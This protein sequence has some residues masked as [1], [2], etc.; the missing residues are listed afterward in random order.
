MTPRRVFM[1]LIAGVLV[2]AG[3]LW[4]VS[5]R[6]LEQAT[7][8]GDLVLPG[9]QKALNEVTEIRVSRGDGSRTTLKKGPTDWLVGE[10]DYPAD[11]GKVRKLLLDLGALSV[12]EEKTRNPEYYPQLGVEDSNSPKAG[13]TLLEIA[14]P[15]KSYALIVGKPARGQSGYVRVAHTAP[16]LLVQPVINVDGDP[17]H[18]IDR[19]VVDVSDQQMKEAVIEPAAGPAYTVARTAPQQN[20]YKVTPLPKGREL[21]SN[22][23]ANSVGSA[24]GS[25]QADDV[26]RAPAAAADAAKPDHG[27]FRTFNGLELEITGRT[28]GEHHYITL[29]ARAN[30]KEAQAEAGRINTRFPGWQIEI[31]AFNYQAIFKP[32]EE[33]LKKPEPPK[34]K[35]AKPAPLKK[36]ASP[37]QKSD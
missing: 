30:S 36:S 3:S 33:L 37:Q 27:I 32:R 19:A 13:G 20:D 7:M 11:S 6:H 23:A 15:G 29:A 4:L 14:T 28:E 22:G 25:L 34:G 8:T 18:W 16:S 2:I 12:V 17:R 31:P 1:L 9:L 21:D 35:T 10:R 24:L 26:R 5:Q